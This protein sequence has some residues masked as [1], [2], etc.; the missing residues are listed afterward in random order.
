MLVRDRASESGWSLYT[1]SA[2]LLLLYCCFTAAL[3]NKMLQVERVHKAA[4]MR[5]K[6]RLRFA[7]CVL[8]LLY[9]CP[10]TT[11]CVLILLY[12]CVLILL[13]MRPHATYYICVLILLHMCPHS[14]MPG[15]ACIPSRAYAPQMS[16]AL[17]YMCPHT[18]A[19]VS[20]YYCICVLILL[21]QVERVYRAAR[22]RRKCR[23]LCAM[24]PHTTTYVSSYY[25][26]C[27]LI[28]LHMCPHTTMPGGACIPSRAYAPQML[29]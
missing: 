7:P 2:A 19:Y 17:R 20:A 8:I 27:V 29:S 25:C 23:L 26:I 3:Q 15:G 11:I 12:M 4:R 22:M 21:C 14:T 5:R 13:D 1:K 16:P 18:T 6:S 9:M 28:L 10:K 24:C